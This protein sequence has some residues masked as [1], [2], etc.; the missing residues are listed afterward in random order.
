MRDGGSEHQP[1][2]GE[3]G[4]SVTVVENEFYPG[5]QGSGRAHR[6]SADRTTRNC[7]TVPPRHRRFSTS[8]NSS[9][10]ESTREKKTVRPSREA[11]MP[12]LTT[13]SLDATVVD[14]PVANS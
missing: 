4:P 9:A 1:P 3:T 5:L 14:R 7:F 12:K 2:A 6:D 8:I 10:D 13:P 11:L